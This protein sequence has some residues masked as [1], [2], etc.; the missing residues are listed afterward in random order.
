MKKTISIFCVALFLLIIFELEAEVIHP[1][2]PGDPLIYGISGGALIAVHPYGIRDPQKPGGP[3]GLIYVGYEEKGERQLVNY[4]AIEPI[5]RGRRNYSEL[6]KGSDRKNGKIFHITNRVEEPPGNDTDF[7]TGTIKGEQGNRSLSF[8]IHPEPFENGSIPVIEVS[9]FENKPDRIRFRA[10]AASGSASMTQCIL[11]ATMGNYSRCRY[12]WLAK[13]SIFAP[14]LYEGYKDSGFIEKESYPYSRLHKTADGGIV[15]VITPDEFDPRET[16]PFPG[17]RS[18][19]YAGK[20]LAQFWYK[21]EGTFD[22][23][24]HCRVNGRYT[25]WAS[26]NPIPGGMAF[27]NFELVEDF[28]PGRESWFGFTD[29]S[30]LEKFGFPYNLPPWKERKRT[31]DASE[32]QYMNEAIKS[33]GILSNADFQ[34]GLENWRKEGDGS[35]FIPSASEKKVTTFQKGRIYQTFIV[36]KNADKMTFLISGAMNPGELYIALW[37]REI[38]WRKATGADAGNPAE[39]RWDVKPLRGKAVTLEICDYSSDPEDFLCIKNLEALG[40]DE[41]PSNLK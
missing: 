13:E 6:E 20:R 27:E 2:K 35:K 12:L 40:M 19:H 1:Q 37:D 8:A 11:T 22:A 41:S 24:L 32:N 15:A 25:Y 30:P 7:P 18:W 26:H 36:P 14:S 23:S 3:R 29:R 5:A 39:I 38:L 10:F 34:N 28:I 31:I 9:L 16:V 17:K 4:I 33:G 21:P